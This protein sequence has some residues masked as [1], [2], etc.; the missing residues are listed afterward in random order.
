MPS[1]EHFEIPAEDMV[2]ARRF[3]QGLFD[4]R[5]EDYPGGQ[6]SL[7]RTEGLQGQPGVGGGLCARQQ[8]DQPVIDYINVDC[9]D[10]YVARV[11]A[12]GGTIATPKT[13]VP[14]VG[15]RCWFRDPEGNTLGLW[16][17]DPRAT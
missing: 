9:L 7:I 12:L 16:Q 10:E 13:A 17:D 6:Y 5:F 4:W 15:W 11:E 3:Y 8:A 14:G 1:I 2:R